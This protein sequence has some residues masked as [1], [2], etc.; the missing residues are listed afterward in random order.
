MRTLGYY[1]ELNETDPKAL[2]KI[3]K[4]KAFRDSFMDFVRELERKGKAGSY[5]VR[6]K[7]VL[8]SW[9]SFNGLDVKLKVNIAKEY[10]T[11]TIAEE[12]V[13]SKE[14]LDRVIRM[15][16]PRARVAIALMAFSG[17]RPQSLGNYTGTDGIRL[18]DFV[19]AEIKPDGIEFKKIPSLLIVRSNLSKARHQYFT[20]IP[21]QTITYIQEYLQRRAKARQ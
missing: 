17:L 8:R 9:F 7:K 21:K 14:E 6:F 3:A 1:C 5:I 18:G 11:P 19:E 13:P 2:L 20:F 15:A 4:T 12:R 16:T 10:E